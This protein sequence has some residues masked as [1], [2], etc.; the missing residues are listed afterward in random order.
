MP[1]RR[2]F[3]ISFKKNSS[4]CCWRRLLLCRRNLMEASISAVSTLGEIVGIMALIEPEIIGLLHFLKAHLR[5]AIHCFSPDRR[6]QY[7][8]KCARRRNFIGRFTAVAPEHL[9]ASCLLVAEAW[10]FWNRAANC[11]AL[12]G[13]DGFTV[14]INEA[15]ISSNYDASGRLNSRNMSRCHHRS[16]NVC[17]IVSSSDVYGEAGTRSTEEWL[18][19]KI[20]LIDEAVKWG[21]IITPGL[22]PLVS[23]YAENSG[24]RYMSSKTIFQP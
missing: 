6:M 4:W 7:D 12:H 22:G 23:S 24:E 15:T 13:Y 18:T 17:M 1:F 19:W 10:N 11:R 16:I 5:R 20:N 14:E 9:R 3:A 8:A 21:R 2:C